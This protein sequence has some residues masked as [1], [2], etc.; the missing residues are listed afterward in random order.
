MTKEEDASE[1]STE[2]VTSDTSDA[3]ARN[4]GRKRSIDESNLEPDERKKLE[5]RRAYNRQCAAKGTFQHAK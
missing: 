5:S 3:E 1:S 2:H 4:V